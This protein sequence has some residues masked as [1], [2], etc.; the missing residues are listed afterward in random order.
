MFPHTISY[1][2]NLTE[3]NRTGPYLILLT[4]SIVKFL[5]ITLLLFVYVSI[6]PDLILPPSLRLSLFPPT[7]IP[8]FLNRTACSINNHLG[9]EQSRRDDLESIAYILVSHSFTFIHSILLNTAPSPS[10]L[11]SPVLSCPVLSCSTIPLS[12]S[13]IQSFKLHTHLC[14]SILLCCAVMLKA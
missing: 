11:F 12:W 5:L 3:P 1:L 4:T 7:S 13:T 9:I 2:P 10:M 6:F 14:P 8:S